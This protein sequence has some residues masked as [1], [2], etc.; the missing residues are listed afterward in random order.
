M[1][2][3]EVLNLPQVFENLKDAKGIG[4]A[5]AL[6]KNKKVI[7]AERDNLLKT[8]P[9]VER[10]QKFLATMGELVKEYCVIEKEG[11]PILVDKVVLKEGLDRAIFT[12]KVNELQIEFAEAIVERRDHIHEYQDFVKEDAD[13]DFY[14]LSEGALPDE[15]T[16]HSLLMLAELINF[17][18]RPKESI[19]LTKYQL[20]TYTSIFK[21]TIDIPVLSTTNCEARNKCLQNFVIFRNEH[22][23]LYNHA[24]IKQWLN[25]EDERKAL[26]ESFAA[27]DIYGDVLIQHSKDSQD[28]QFV[29]KDMEAYKVD[30]EKL[31]TKYEKELT[32]FYN[33]LNEKMSIGICKIFQDELPSDISLEDLQTLEL[34]IQIEMTN[35]CGTSKPKPGKPSK[36]SKPKGK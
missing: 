9:T 11:E 28:D 29:I 15:L 13:V 21:N 17:E 33:F 7:D 3:I 8:I 20:L 27:T 25:Y 10:Y 31:N 14:R 18:E 24:I 6:M 2:R 30:L 16:L 26:A 23:K 19:E 12:S 32:T 5:Y 1:K 36:P 22:K 34:F 4:F 35:K